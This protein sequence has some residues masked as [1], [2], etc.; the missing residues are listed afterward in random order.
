VSGT[1]VVTNVACNGGNTGAINLTPTGGT[2]PYTFLWNGGVTTEDRTGLTAGNYSVVI[3]DA[4]GCTG[5]VNATVTQAPALVASA[6]SQTNV[7][8]NGGAN[9]SATVAV[10][11]GTGSYTYSW[12]PAGGTA[13]TATGLAAGTYTVTVTDANG[14]TATQSF[15]ITQ[16][17]A[18][19][20]NN[21]PQDD[22][23]NTGD[24]ATF[25]VNASN[26]T[27]YQ[28]QVSTDGTNWNDVTDGGTNP[29]YSG[30][31]TN[32]L[33]VTGVPVTFDG[34]QYRVIVNAGINCETTSEAA[35]LNVNNELEAVDDDFSATTINE[36]VGG[37]AGDVTLNDLFN[38]AA[39]VDTDVTIS[40]VNDGGMT[41][42]TIAADGTLSVPASAEEGIYTITYSICDVANSTN[43][44]TAEVT[45]VVG[46][47]L[48]VKEFNAMAVTV[49][50]NPAVN[51]V[52][53][54]VA[55]IS[56]HH[57]AKVVV[58]DMNGRMVI[59]RPLVSELETINI[60]LL[61]SGIYIFNITSDMGKT[62][63][64]I[65]KTKTE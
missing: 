60:S 12:A 15:T 48:G 3:T 28:W 9:G 31:A 25:T 37:V 14:C 64:R 23:V 17:A 36:G 58:Y 57:D 39:V 49:Y 6:S 8:C 54:K 42:V 52:Y 16:P 1:T 51:E 40:V 11:G 2:G 5:T 38:G 59:E 24:T 18:V 26:A 22:T 7:A 44:S 41:G 65:I 46:P 13:A 61:E 30:A 53:I 33:T 29:A 55:D 10:T 20:I 35:T 4:N 34:Y 27:G 62:T 56:S 43:C 21:Q 63:K 47:P 45:V 19:V 32:T 50:P